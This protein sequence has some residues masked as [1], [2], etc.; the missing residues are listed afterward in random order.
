MSYPEIIFI[1]SSNNPSPL[2][3]RCVIVSRLILNKNPKKY[4]VIGHC[5]A[6]PTLRKGIAN[7]SKSPKNKAFGD[8]AMSSAARGSRR[9][10]NDELTARI[11]ARMQIYIAA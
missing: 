3:Q 2:L 5:A 11:L 1:V 8:Q 6:S 4:R 7:A 9:W 10:P